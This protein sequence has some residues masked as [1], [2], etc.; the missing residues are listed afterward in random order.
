[1]V[2]LAGPESMMRERM[3]FEVLNCE[4]VSSYHEENVTEQ[5]PNA[6]SALD[7]EDRERLRSY[8]N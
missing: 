5:I 8:A 7:Q 6:K 4:I 2:A 1:M 3:V